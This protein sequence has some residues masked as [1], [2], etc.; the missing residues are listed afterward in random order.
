MACAPW[1]PQWTCDVECLSPAVTGMAVEIA[2]ETV[3]A[4]SGR[5]FGNCPVTFRPCRRNCLEGNWLA[6]WREWN[7]PQ[8]ALIGGQWFNL[9]CGSCGDSCSCSSLSQVVLPGPVNAITQ[10]KIDGSP[11]VTGAYRVDD[12]RILV[13][14]DGGSWPS[15]NDLS[16]PD[17]AAGTWSITAQFGLPVPASG[18][19][20][21][22]ELACELAKSLNGEACRLPRAVTNVTRQ[23]VTINYGDIKDLFR[24]GLTG[25]FLVDSFIQATNPRHLMDRARVYSVDSPTGRRTTWP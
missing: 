5:Q 4:L 10:V 20:A 9:T 2:T 25:L 7:Y 8:P 12:Y 1:T 21:V 11:L 18:E 22:G 14:Q 16:K 6:G 23:G 15:C 17:D 13:R 24:G 19:L 3:W